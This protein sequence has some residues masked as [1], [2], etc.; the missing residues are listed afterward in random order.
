VGINRQTYKLPAPLSSAV[1]EALADW[2]RQEKVRRLWERDA[3]LWTGGD[4]ARWLDWLTIVSE[5]QHEIPTLKAFAEEIR[6]AGFTQ[7][8]LLGMGGSSLC[9]EV[10]KE[11]FGRQEGYPELF[12]LDSTDPAQIRT[13]DRRLDLSRTL[14]IVSSKSGSTLEP[15]IFKDYFLSR[16][17]E[18]VGE[19][20][21]G[22]HFVAITDPG[23]NLQRAAEADGFRRIFFG[24]AGIGGRYSALSHFGT[25]PA[26]VIGLDLERFL[27]STAEMVEACASAPAQENPGVILGC[28]LGVLASAGRDKVTLF[29]SPGIHDLGAWLEQL[30][31]ESTGKQGKGLIPVDREPLGG[32]QAYNQDRVF[33]YLRLT[34]EADAAQDAAVADLESAGQPVIRIELADRYDLGQELFRWEIATAVAGS[35]LKVHPFDQP[36]VEASKVATRELT[37]AYEKTGSLPRE[38]PLLEDSG[39]SLFADPANTDALRRGAGAGAGLEAILRTHLGR[40]Q[41][42]DYFAL[43]VYVEMSTEHETLLSAMRLAVRDRK[44]VATCVG[45]GPRF[46]H[47]T[48]QAYKG[49]PDSGLFLQITCDDAVDLPV[50]GRKLTFGVVQ[51]AQAQGDFQVLSERRRR[52]LRVHLQGEPQ[53]GL[54]RLRAALDRSLV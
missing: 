1:S 25:V 16:L 40:L 45:F 47:S 50:P 11:T 9:P 29:A 53:A 28:M 41:A 14:C 36:D 38:K 8:V 19:S 48:G 24:V 10:L 7:V 27:G 52:A 54:R 44:L 15:N 22:S 43:L 4:E 21:A 46:L 12:V 37:T 30:L 32:P 23:S 39:L 3:S 49:G 5:Q 26:A 2:R 20:A 33:A 51:A 6:Q 34:A 17:R 35:I 31:A 18:T 42:G 13:L